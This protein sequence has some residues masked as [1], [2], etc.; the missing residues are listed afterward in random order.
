MS[1]APNGTATKTAPKTKEPRLPKTAIE[2]ER[3]VLG[4]M[5][6]EAPAA[7]IGIDRL[8][9]KDF[10]LEDH[11]K[12]FLAVEAVL[13]KDGVA[14]VFLVIQE[15]QDRKQLDGLAATTIASGRAYLFS[16]VNATAHTAHT[17]HY[18]NEVLE[19]SLDRQVEEQCV[20]T[21]QDKTPEN[22]KRLHELLDALYA[23]R[24]YELFDFKTDLHDFL[25]NLQKK[26]PEVIDT[27]FKSLDRILGGLNPG[28]L[29]TIGARTSGGKTA[30]MVKTCLQ[31]AETQKL[32]CLYITTEMTQDQIVE[33]VLPMAATVQSWRFR[34]R[35]FDAEDWR[36]IMD[37]CSSRLSKLDLYVKGKTTLLLS[38]IRTAIKMANPRVVFVDYLQRCVFPEGETRAYQVMDFMKELKTLALDLKINVIIGCQLNRSLDT[39]SER[40]PEN[41]DL[42]DSGGI[43][44]ESD[45]VVLLW[46]PSLKRILKEQIDVPTGHHL[47]RAKVSKN[48]HGRAFDNADLLLHGKYVDMIERVAEDAQQEL[49]RADLA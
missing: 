8:K 40:E 44:A 47:I 42:K 46:K 45:S 14:D 35:A 29:T 28:D 31:M 12:I 41:S 11:R 6:I 30:F 32:R 33:R 27:G 15:L 10:Y 19:A 49:P 16:L 13:K 26:P 3:A 7:Q 20:R 18:A 36:K 39:D 17:A 34:K 21:A 5:L 23:V 22:L 38:D 1:I 4:A 48:R 24:E 25:D 9:P 2:A 37:A 43:E